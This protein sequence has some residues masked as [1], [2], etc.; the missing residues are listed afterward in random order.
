MHFSKMVEAK[1]DIVEAGALDKIKSLIK[2]GVMTLIP[3]MLLWSNTGFAKFKNPE[4]FA[5]K[6]EKLA[7]GASF[8]E[9]KIET[10]IISTGTK[11]KQIIIWT[12]KSLG[13]SVLVKYTE[14][15]P[16]E[17]RKG[18]AE[19][20]DVDPQLAAFGKEVAD[21]LNDMTAHERKP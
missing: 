17:Y 16:V 12:I 4:E 5:K 1:Y 18:H 15:K 19:Y 21:V 20:G 9:A 11:G 6:L 10:H 13:D 7:H 8:E 3:T 2:K 14:G